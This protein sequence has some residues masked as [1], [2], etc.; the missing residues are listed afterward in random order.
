[1]SMKSQLSRGLEKDAAVKAKRKL[2]SELVPE[3]MRRNGPFIG[4]H[5]LAMM[6]ARRELQRLTQEAMRPMVWTRD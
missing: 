5:L 2:E 1:M 3:F 4:E 6:Y